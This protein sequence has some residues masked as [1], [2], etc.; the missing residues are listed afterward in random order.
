MMIII[1][2]NI[3]PMV[4]VLLPLYDFVLDCARFGASTFTTCLTHFGSF[5]NSQ[6]GPF[7]NAE[8]SN[9]LS[10]KHTLIGYAN[11]TVDLWD[12]KVVIF[13]RTY[14]KLFWVCH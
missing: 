9:M 13:K 6:C 11:G 8:N 14:I 7:D 10:M 12:L 3:I 4:I 2:N 1:I 5:S